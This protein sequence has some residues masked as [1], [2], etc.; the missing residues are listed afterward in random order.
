M[1]ISFTILNKYELSSYCV[2]IQ[3]QVNAET[4]AYASIVIALSNE[5][6]SSLLTLPSI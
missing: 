2:T 6:L 1:S 5:K 4:A 3:N